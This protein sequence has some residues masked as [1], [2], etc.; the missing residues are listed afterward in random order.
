M[1]FRLCDPPVA[2]PSKT[3]NDLT[4]LAAGMIRALG[5]GHSHFNQGVFPMTDW[6]YDTSYKFS[7]LIACNTNVCHDVY[8]KGTGSPNA[9][10][11]LILQ[12]LPGI[13]AETYALA[14]RLVDAG[15][16]VY[17]PHL[18]GRLGKAN[19]LTTIANTARLL[20]IRREFSIFATG[21][22][23]P[24]AAWMRALCAD[25][26]T[27]SGGQKIGCIGMCL[28]G[29]F[30]IPL[31]AED[32]VA[33]AVASQPALPIRHKTKLH[34][35]QS[36]VTSACAAME[37]KGP[38]LAM[39]YADDKIASKQHMQALKNAFGAHLSVQ[40]FPGSAHSLLTLDFNEDAYQHMQDYFKARFGMA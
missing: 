30:A 40:E 9:P 21:R 14:D 1:T 3:G 13:G 28:T 15:F 18:L 2:L 20:C 12:E 23:S 22:Q 10:P 31:M 11:I 19:R 7:H 6:Q 36:D 29:C 4:R 35:S 37:T 32:A 16:S 39:R 24:I 34:M 5:S 17:L 33:G 25:I 26:A 38:A 8:V 27:R